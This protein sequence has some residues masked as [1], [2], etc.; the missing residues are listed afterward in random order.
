VDWVGW[1]VFGFGATVL[2]TSIMAG[3][4]LAGWTRVDIPY[5]LGTIVVTDPDRARVVGFLMHL[6]NGQVFGLFYAVAFALLG[7]ATWWWGS[8]FGLFHGLV[9]V[10]V[11]VPL[12]PGVNPRM[13]SDRAGPGFGPALEPPGALALN[14]GGAT[15]AVALAAHVAYGALLGTF[16]GP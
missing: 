12:V 2:L 10:G 7:R 5:L 6:V 11:L 3:A 15:P 13:A 4:Q 9:A 14:Y 8:L 1:A 16:L